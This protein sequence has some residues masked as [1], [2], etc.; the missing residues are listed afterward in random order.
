M[1]N[2]FWLITCF[3]IHVVKFYIANIITT[4][5]WHWNQFKCLAHLEIVRFEFCNA[6]NISDFFFNFQFSIID[7]LKSFRRNVETNKS[8]CNQFIFQQSRL[9][10][11]RD[12]P[13][14]FLNHSTHSVWYLHN[15]IKYMNKALHEFFSLISSDIINCKLRKKKKSFRIKEKLLVKLIIQN[16]KKWLL[17]HSFCPLIQNE[18][19]NN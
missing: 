15:D 2:C 17:Q 7:K 5:S 4:A 3:G 10:N 12:G 18:L 1:Y 8:F 16:E 19:Q 14:H 11:R 9:E 6:K 13:L